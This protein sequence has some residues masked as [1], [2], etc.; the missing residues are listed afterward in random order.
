MKLA[1]LNMGEHPTRLTL[2]CM[3]VLVTFVLLGVSIGIDAG[4][5]RAG[6]AGS[7]ERQVVV[8]KLGLIHPLPLWYGNLIEHS[9][10]V[11]SSTFVSL[12]PA[13][14]GA[15]QPPSV[16]FATDIARWTAV[17]PE[18]KIREGQIT[19][20][21]RGNRILVGS[22]LAEQMGW[23]IGDRIAVSSPIW[24]RADG[25]PQWELEVSGIFDDP[26]AATGSTYGLLDFDSFDQ[27]RLNGKGTVN[28]Y[29]INPSRDGP[30]AFVPTALKMAFANAEAEVDV[31]AEAA[32]GAEFLKQF[33][34]LRR[35]LQ[36]VLSAAV[37]SMIIITANMISMSVSARSMVWAT[38]R[39]I[40]FSRA[41]IIW[42]VCLEAVLTTLAPAVLGCAL[43]SIGLKM[44][45]K[46]LHAEVLLAASPA[47]L[48]VV[49]MPLAL[50][51]SLIAAAAPAAFAAKVSV[52]SAFVRA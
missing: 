30:S 49:A 13:Q 28:W 40:G 15:G 39:A 37:L 2:G 7:A 20:A 31:A 26:K 14:S 18:M 45:G 36:L 41:R 35:I 34:D 48:W 4:L 44:I 12:F 10:G 29:V 8:N 23:K 42:I 5:R 17:Y 50:A 27:A 33:S 47:L 6:H 3:V 32:F 22:A 1:L 9:P 38:L 51:I 21:G 24:L 43:A 16:F 25:A 11:G 46:G 19:G 52:Q